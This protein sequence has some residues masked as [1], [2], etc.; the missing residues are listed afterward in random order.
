MPRVK[1]VHDKGNK[2]QRRPAEQTLGNIISLRISDH[3][4]KLLENVVKRSSI[5]ISDAM[6]EAMTH[7]L[8]SN[9]R[10]CLD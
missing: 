10:L 1:N 6:R 7:W 5:N 8:N 9:N 4:K 2:K 3:E